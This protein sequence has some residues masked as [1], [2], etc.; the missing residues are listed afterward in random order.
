MF[1]VINI[2]VFYVIPRFIF[3][4]CHD[5]PFIIEIML[6][7]LVPAVGV[8]EKGDWDPINTHVIFEVYM[9]LIIQGTIPTR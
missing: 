4:C 7:N 9:G 6:P 5:D 3:F 2:C 8:L 1:F